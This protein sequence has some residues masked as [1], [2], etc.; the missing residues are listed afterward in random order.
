TIFI[1]HAHPDHYFG[2]QAI[3]AKFPN[4]E[5]LA[6]PEV[7]EQMKTL[8]PQ[9]V[10]QW[11]PLYGADLTDAPL[12]PRSFDGDHLSL[13][14]RRI[15]LVELEPGEVEYSTVV[16]IPS[17]KTAVTGDLAY[18]G[19]HVWLA[20]A[21]APRREGWLRNVKKVEALTPEVVIPGHEVPGSEHAA[22]VLDSTAQY[23]R[24]F[25]EAVKQSR[26]AADVVAK[27][28]AIYGTRRLPVVLDIAAQA[29]F[30]GR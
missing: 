20:E 19:T 7:V 4:A 18:G 29:A 21:D 11:K 27:M 14:G 28:S 22:A 16:Y 30:A 6:A 3:T 9:K 17:I 15:D 5:I 23:I 24:D 8:G 2:L 13:E 12:V 25:D 1:T 10:A 26:S